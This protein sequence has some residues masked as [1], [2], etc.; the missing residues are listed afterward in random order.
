MRVIFS[1]SRFFFFLVQLRTFEWPMMVVETK[2][3]KN[4]NLEYLIK[5]LN[6]VKMYVSVR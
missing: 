5:Y 3:V 6:R 2:E 1:T 4:E